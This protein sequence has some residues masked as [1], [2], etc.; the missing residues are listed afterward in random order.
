MSRKSLVLALV[1][2]LLLL[3]L[4]PPAVYVFIPVDRE[5]LVNPDRPSAVI[6]DRNGV[7][8]RNV[9]SD[10]GCVFTGFVPSDEISDYMKKAIV[11]IEDR[12]FYSHC[13]VEMRSILRAMLMNLREMRVVAGG[14]TIT[15]Q[16]AKIVLGNNDRNLLSKAREALFALRLERSLSKDEILAAYLNR[17]SFGPS[18][19]GI[20]AAS[21][22]YFA[23]RPSELSAAQSALLAGIPLHPSW[24]DPCRNPE[25]AEGR[26]RLVL[27]QMLSQGLVDERVYREAVAERIEAAEP[28]FPFLAPHFCD[29]VLERMRSGGSVPVGRVSTT[30]DYRLQKNAEGILKACLMRLED[31][32]VSNGAVLVLDSRTGEILVMAGSR[33]FFA[34]D[35]QNNGCLALRQAGS[36]LKPFLYA[37]ALDSGRSIS[38]ALPDVRMTIN[39]PNGTFMPLNYDSSFHGPVSMRR[40]LAC[41][42]NIPALRVV[43]D[44]GVPEFI[45]KLSEL[46][47]DSVS[48]SAERYGAGIALGNAEISLL[49]LARAYGCFVS[50]GEVHDLRYLSSGGRAPSGARRVFSPQSSYIIFDVLSDNSARAPAFGLSS[51]LRTPFPCAVKTGTTK[52]YR[53]NWCVGVTRDYVVGVWVGNFDNSPMRNVS[54]VTGA[55]PV[56]AGVM[57]MLYE[58][59]DYPSRPD[60]PEGLV[61]GRV[62]PLS[63]MAVSDCCP[64]G[65]DEL[66]ISEPPS[67]RCSWHRL[68]SIDVRTGRRAAAGT[69]PELVAS[70]KIE[71]L[72]PVYNQWLKERGIRP[73][74]DELIPNFSAGGARLSIIFPSDGDVFVIDE[75]AERHFQRISFEADFSGDGDVEWSINGRRL[76]TSGYPHRLDWPLERGD[77]VLS[78]SGGGMKSSVSFSVR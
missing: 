34:R 31:N 1:A 70:R 64:G 20:G 46:G 24:Y 56:F 76:G 14:S 51:P 36:S 43:S 74:C 73:F 47:F 4:V 44:V 8:L 77:Y 42:Y 21:E 72:P 3:I 16:L 58:K 65:V 61:S 29:F 18:V 25:G 48:G 69:P 33:D 40:A 13:G 62:C 53:D 45:Q 60:R 54:G 30:L 35:G 6:E 39:D 10:S 7:V 27:S 23:R 78:A 38:E 63:G 57:A 11:S 41:S 32:N 52:N 55:G 22:F 5:S 15:Q 17:V 37:M 50:R 68:E 9:V 28:D 12:R 59:G 71:V 66:F 19:E 26:K 75:A 2:L 67:E 49:S